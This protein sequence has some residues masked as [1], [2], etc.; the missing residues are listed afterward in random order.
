MIFVF[1]P[2]RPLFENQLLGS[3]KK[4]NNSHGS[5]ARPA[6]CCCNLI[7]WLAPTGEATGRWLQEQLEMVGCFQKYPESTQVEILVSRYNYI[8][9]SYIICRQSGY[10]YIEIYHINWLAFLNHQQFRD[11]MY[12]METFPKEAGILLDNLPWGRL[13]SSHGAV[14]TSTV[15]INIYKSYLDM[16]LLK[17]WTVFLRLTYKIIRT[18]PSKHEHQHPTVICSTPEVNP[19]VN[20]AECHLLEVL[21]LP[22]NLGSKRCSSSWDFEW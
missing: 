10:L 6:N 7:G 5:A 4:K 21:L 20:R 16:S 11:K 19:D 9:M 8:S 18:C 3:P 14:L 13:D 2:P 1:L 17:K 22:F 12:P 15:T